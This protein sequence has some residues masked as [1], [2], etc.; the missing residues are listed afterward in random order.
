MIMF[1]GLVL[2]ISFGLILER[3]D[4][5]MACAAGTSGGDTMSSERYRRSYD[6]RV[7]RSRERYSW[8]YVLLI[9]SHFV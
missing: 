9:F 3:R 7:G 8:R 2:G 5:G 1:L 4:G 6:D